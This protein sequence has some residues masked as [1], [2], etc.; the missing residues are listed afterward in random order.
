M[1]DDELRAITWEGD[2]VRLIDQ[3]RL[4]GEL[5][6]LDIDEVD[7]LVDAIARL[8]VRG[9]PAL[10]AAG[11]LGVVVALRQAE[12]EGWDDATRD[13]AI[14]RVR[15]ARPTA[16]NLAWGVDRVLAQLPHGT[17]AVLA[18]ALALIREDEEA[19]RAL[20]R[21]GADWI[22]QRIPDRPIRVLTHC[23]TGMLATTAWGTAL[24]IVR[25][26]AT[27]D[28]IELVYVDE[29]RP[30]LQGARLTAW[31]LAEEGIAHRVQVDGAAAS[32]IL[33]GMVDVAIIGADRIAANGD[34]AN[35]IGSVGVALA[36]ADAGVPFLVAAPASTVDPATRSGEEIEIEE[37]AAEEV[38]FFAS[39][40]T[41]PEASP[42]FNPAFDVTPA[43]LISAIV[44]EVGAE[45]PAE[46]AARLDAALT[47]PA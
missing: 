11:A 13:A 8:A 15:D 1:A 39:D 10:G 26:L 28:A 25:E 3:T 2:H 40:R 24:G 7:P 18:D 29:T 17:E 6:M 32:T 22:Q 21:A 36:C 12:R 44:T 45:T 20:G 19:N 41:A 47:V 42:A 43:R 46:L 4:P 34:T 9:A 37:R 27:R 33:R 14:T 16:I 38:T 5:V 23:N 30:L 31:E 35:K